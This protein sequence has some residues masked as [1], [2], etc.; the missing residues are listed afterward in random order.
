MDIDFHVNSLEVIPDYEL[1]QT[2][3]GKLSKKDMPKSKFKELQ[4]I[5]LADLFSFELIQIIYRK[6]KV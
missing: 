1:K 5:L 2:T 3:T 6:M 4:A